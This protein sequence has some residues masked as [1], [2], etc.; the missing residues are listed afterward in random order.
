MKRTN[1]NIY[2]VLVAWLLIS[3]F[4]F[5]YVSK[6]FHHH[7]G[8]HENTSCSDHSHKHSKEKECL[9]CDF[10]LPV[11]LEGKV[12][13]FEIAGQLIIALLPDLCTE[14]RINQL[15]FPYQLRAPPH[16]ILC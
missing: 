7:C 8:N 14:E 12:G 5:I 6:V 11:F 1:R 15:N 3:A 10:M 2:K 16:K 9:I 13:K 4:S